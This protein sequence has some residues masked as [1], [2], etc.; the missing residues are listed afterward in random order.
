[1]SFPHPWETS[2][3]DIDPDDVLFYKTTRKVGQERLKNLTKVFDEEC[4]PLATGVTGEV[5]A[6]QRDNC[7]LRRGPPCDRLNMVLR[8]E[9]RPSV[10]LDSHNTGALN[11]C[12]LLYHVLPAKSWEEFQLYKLWLML[13][14]SSTRCRSDELRLQRLKQMGSFA[15]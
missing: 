11:R 6:G 4:A 15:T 9:K 8:C 13:R 1:M 3:Q 5:R 14:E 10:V 2:L 12:V 7:G